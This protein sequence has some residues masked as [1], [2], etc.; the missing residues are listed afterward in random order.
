MIPRFGRYTAFGIALVALSLVFGACGGN[1][2]SGD[3]HPTPTSTLQPPTNSETTPADSTVSQAATDFSSI[4]A[5]LKTAIAQMDS[6]TG[7]LA[8][9]L[10]GACV[11]QAI[12]QFQEAANGQLQ[13]L[14]EIMAALDAA[15]ID[16]SSADAEAA[17]NFNFSSVDEA[18]AAIA[19]NTANIQSL[20]DQGQQA[21]TELAAV[22]G[23]SGSEAYMATQQIWDQNASELNDALD[24][25]NNAITA[26]CG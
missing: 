12:L 25:L 11:Q 23:G 19:A 7:E 13:Q 1:S 24:N 2:S 21:L 16:Y 5:Q 3:A 10:S 22:W 20:L 8:G 9:Q 26:G 18:I 6:I 17:Q 15:G 4:A 14:S